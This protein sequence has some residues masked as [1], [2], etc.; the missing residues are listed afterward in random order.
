MAR[1]DLIL[2]DFDGTIV[3]TVGDIAHYTN[4]TLAVYGYPKRP[5]G[6]VR[7]AIGWGVHELLK[8][9]A[10]GFALDAP[11]LEEAVAYFKKEYRADPVKT[12]APFEGV[13]PMLEGPLAKIKKAIVT[14]KP[15]DITEEILKRLNL[16]HYF[17]MTIGMHA[18]FPPKPDPAA[19]LHVM[20]SLE[21]VPARTVYVG[22]SGVDAALAFNAGIDFA[23]VS[24][25]YDAAEKA[26][27][28][29][30]FSSATEWWVLAG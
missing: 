8:A 23:W 5:V 3:D 18:G 12:T 22:D 30:T 1:Y 11:K 24:Y 26:K 28:L 14:N 27:P 29:F 2:F 16:T 19:A 7:K 25:G 10:P 20:R 13:L 4:E 21:T 17:E 6:D 9:L 15:Q